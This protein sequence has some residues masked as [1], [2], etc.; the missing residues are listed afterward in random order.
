MCGGHRR[1]RG[2][3]TAGGQGR[4]PTEGACFDRSLW[5]F[6]WAAMGI[7]SETE[8]A[9]S[10]SAGR[11][12]QALNFFPLLLA[13]LKCRINIPQCSIV[14]CACCCSNDAIVLITANVIDLRNAATYFVLRRRSFKWSCVL[15]MH[16]T[17]SEYCKCG[18]SRVYLNVLVTSNILR[19][20]HWPL[21]LLLL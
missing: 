3:T 1:K 15:F 12:S 4:D 19:L 8:L 6:A 7:A 5:H 13:L 20:L 14:L 2:F 16:I 10:F 17:I 11:Y 21:L 18:P 9:R